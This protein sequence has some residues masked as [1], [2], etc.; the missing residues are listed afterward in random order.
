MLCAFKHI[1]GQEGKGIHSLRIFGLAAVDVVMTVAGCLIISVVFK[2]NF[3]MVFFVAMIIAILCHRLLC[4][5]TT[6][7]KLIFGIV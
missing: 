5:N 1:A 7:N 4:V 2:V 6:I 3:W